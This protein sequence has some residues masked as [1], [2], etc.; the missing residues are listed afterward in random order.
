[1]DGSFTSHGRSCADAG[2]PQVRLIWEDVYPTT[3]C[4]F[5]CAKCFDAMAM[6]DSPSIT[7]PVSLG[8]AAS[9]TGIQHRKPR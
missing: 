8:G 3:R 7:V 4:N 9:T 1:M 2:D 6:T 5:T